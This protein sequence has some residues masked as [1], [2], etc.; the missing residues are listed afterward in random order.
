MKA[1]GKKRAVILSTV[2]LVLGITLS[3][4]VVRLMTEPVAGPRNELEAKYG[5]KLYSQHDEELIIRDFF[6]DRRNGFF[7]DVGASHYRIEST[8]YFLEEHLNWSGIAI[9][10]LSQYGKDYARFRPKTRFYSFFVS[11]KSD[12]Q[13]KFY[14]FRRNLRLSTGDKPTAEQWGSY[15]ETLVPTITLNDL[16]GQVG[17]SGIDFLS[18]DIELNEPKALAGFDIDRFR[19]ELVCI[20]AHEPV[21]DQIMDYFA[22]HSYVEI[23]KYS[24]LDPLNKYFTRST[25]VRRFESH[26]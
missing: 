10:A 24:R 17:V 2:S 7:L 15:D 5:P 18:M 20:E 9:D 13:A 1:I 22:R 4:T 23:E 12:D 21:R 14:V 6:K 19:P 3:F 26:N 25:S 8:T 11:D 16:L